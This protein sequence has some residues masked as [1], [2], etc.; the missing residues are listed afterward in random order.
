MATN[1]ANVVLNVIELFL[2]QAHIKQDCN[3][4]ADFENEVSLYHR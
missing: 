1:N 4:T 2:D 3:A